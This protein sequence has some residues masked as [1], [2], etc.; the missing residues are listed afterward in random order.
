M[1]RPLSD[2]ADLQAGY[3]FR[4][5]VPVVADGNA[6]A[7]QMRDVNADE[8]VM[9]DGLARTQV[10]SRRSGQWL[11]PGDILFVARGARTY[12]VCIAD[13]PVPAVC[14]QVFFHL[15]VKNSAQVL[16]AFLAWQIN[17][18]PAQRYL[19]SNA[20]GTDQLSIRRAVLENL[21]IGLPDLRRQQLIVQVADNARE[22]K[23]RLEAL[24]HNHQK[25][26]DAIAAALLKNRNSG[27][28]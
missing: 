22:Q 2:L 8:G 25:E 10:Q 18:S 24:I 12:A 16:P 14:S 1:I 6:F 17:R 11:Q 19:A 28:A 13:V 15:R 7:V 27:G 23:R 9:W 5:S 21:P 4:G 20:E 26:L 3:P